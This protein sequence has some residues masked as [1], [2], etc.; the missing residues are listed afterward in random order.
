MLVSE[1]WSSGLVNVPSSVLAR[2][3]TFFTII[4]VT[5]IGMSMGWITGYAINP[6]R[7]AAGPPHQSQALNSRSLHSSDFGPRVVLWILGYGTQVWTHN[8]AWWIVGARC[9]SHALSSGR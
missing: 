7:Y 1:P 2:K 8:H 9:V 4:V 3:L 6:A 5:A